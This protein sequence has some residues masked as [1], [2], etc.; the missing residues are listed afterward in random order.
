MPRR[1]P[2]AAARELAKQLGLRQVILLAWDGERTHVV[3]YG[4]TV[5]DC[6]QAAQGGDK[7]KA[8]LGWPE[9]LNAIPSRVKALQ[10]KVDRLEAAI[11][12][13]LGEGDKGLDRKASGLFVHLAKALEA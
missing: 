11:S 13:A 8:A 5:E 6:D 7:L 10:A 4:K 2:I 3:T 12:W 1:I 9:S